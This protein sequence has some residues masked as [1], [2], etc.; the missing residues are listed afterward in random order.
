MKRI[1]ISVIFVTVSS[2]LAAKVS[3]PGLISDN[4]VLQQKSEVMLW[5][6][7]NP[8]SKVSI[9]TS[10]DGKRSVVAVDKSGAWKVHV[11]TPS[12][13]GPYKLT[14]DDGEVTEI[15]NVLVGEVWLC[16]GQSNMVM[17]MKGYTSQPVEDAIEYVTG[18]KASQPIRICTIK[19]AAEFETKTSCGAK[20][21]K[22]VPSDVSTSS[23]TAY[24]FAKRLQE[25]L[26]VPVGII[27]TAW[28][29]SKI[30]AWM[31]RQVLEDFSPE[32][33][34]NFLEARVRSEKLSQAP[35]MLYNGM[36]APLKDYLVKGVIW[37]QGCANTDNAELYY[38]LQPAFV[39]MLREMW[40]NTSLPFYYVQIAPYK[41]SG[42]DNIEAALLRE[43]QT[44]ALKVI[45]HSGM[46]VTMDCGEPRCIHPA[47]KKVV[48]D[49]LAYLALQ[50]TYGMRGIDAITP[51]YESH[52]ISGDKVFVRF[53]ETIM[54]V[55][56]LGRN[57]EGFEVAGCDRVFYPATAHP[58]KDGLKIVVSSK[59][60]KEPV[61]VRY[62]FKN[63]AEAS[64][65][66][67]FGIPASPFRTDDWN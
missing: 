63:Y 61:A 60:V 67:T 66:N 27:V 58:T 62:I 65:F 37:Y 48:G 53:T 21:C 55:G 1:I 51:L 42:Y 12:A 26:D 46:V 49:R 9:I 5:G 33:D 24:F 56:P 50:K 4:M 36:L 13:G 14:F 54:G 28:G 8:R 6:T 23:A 22:N 64:V 47:K 7:A 20:W 29:G 38:R 43:A 17:Q 44:E 34:L 35:T 41:Y 19:R 32:V 3:L 11:R 59:F 57:L 39:N 18:A 2:V 25:T 30:E 10:W 31:S 40:A 15:N 45:P 16:S 52:E